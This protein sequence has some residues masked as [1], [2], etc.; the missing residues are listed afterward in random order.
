MFMVKASSCRV[1]GTMKW[2]VLVL[3]AEQKSR[4]WVL[5]GA[6]LSKPHTCQTASPTMYVCMYLSIYRTSFHK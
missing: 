1:A 3:I 5:I 2:N 4:K 6:S